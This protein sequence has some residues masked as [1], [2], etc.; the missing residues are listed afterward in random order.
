MR[1]KA[2]VTE[3][4]RIGLALIRAGFKDSYRNKTVVESSIKLVIDKGKTIADLPDEELAHLVDY[5]SID[6]RFGLDVL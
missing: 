2:E 5:A 4:D 1:G 6:I 3:D